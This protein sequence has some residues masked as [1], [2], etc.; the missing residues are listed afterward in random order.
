MIKEPY[1]SH[2]LSH[3][4]VNPIVRSF[5]V[6]ETLL[7]SAWNFIFP[8]I[9]L[10]VVGR[11]AGGNVE[12]VAEAYSVYLITRVI[13]E[14]ISGR[15]LSKMS[16]RVKLAMA[17]IGM[18][19]LSLAYASFLFVSTYTLLFGVYALIGFGLGISS[20]AKYA[21]FSTHLNRTKASTEWSI[22]DAVSFTGMAIAGVIGGFVANNYGFD[23]LFLAACALN[24]AGILPYIL[25][26]Q[27]THKAESV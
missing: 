18:L 19:M 17:V 22:Y 16:D 7:W 10:F 24:L 9:A 25:I 6:S 20:P 23:A 1:L 8:I 4:S 2:K 12:V 11:V 21:L 14:L 13:A 26:Y 3:F 5:I 15:V 27:Q